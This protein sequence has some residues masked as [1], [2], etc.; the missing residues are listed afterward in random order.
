MTWEQ[1]ELFEEWRQVVGYEGYYEVSNFGRVRSVAKGT[2]RK[3]GKLLTQRPHIHDQYLSVVLSTA[4]KGPKES[5]V[6]RLV[7]EAFT[8]SCPIGKQVDHIDGNRQNNVLPN[9]RYV[10]QSENRRAAVERRGE[11]AINSRPPPPRFGRDNSATKLT[12][13]QVIDVR[14]LVM[15][16]MSLGAVAKEFDV[17]TSA[18]WLIV[19]GKN[20]RRTT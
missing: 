7:L 9:L 13:D 3:T 15:E 17:S 12:R 11:W 1:I 8:G 5:K 19:H 4:E 10:T 2:G 6:H 16:G 20:H 14:R 18:I